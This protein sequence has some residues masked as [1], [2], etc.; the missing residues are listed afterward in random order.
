MSL[1]ARYTV[2]RKIA[3]GGT[4]E[5]FLAVQHGAKGFQKNVVLKRIHTAYYADPQFRNMLIDEAH[6]AMSLNHGN[7]VQV[8]D[9]GEAAGRYFLALELVDG[10]TAEQVLRRA[11]AVGV[12][13]PTELALYVAGEVCR[14]LAYAHA[15]ATD[16]RPLGIVHRDISTHNVLISEQGEVKLTDFGIAKINKREQSAG[17]VIKGKVAF[18]SPEQA[19]GETLDARSDI[20]SMGTMLYAM[21]TGRRPFDA[22]TDLETLFLVKSAKFAPPTP[23]LN[24][25]VSRIILKAMRKAP[26]ERYQKADE[27]LQ[28]IE[29]VMRIG[30]PPVG[31]TELKQWLGDLGR[32]DSA[33]PLTKAAAAAAPSAESGIVVEGGE[34]G[35][36]VASD[37]VM[38]PPAPPPPPP[39]G[40]SVSQGARP[41]GAAAAGRTRRGALAAGSAAVALAVVALAVTRGWV[42]AETPPQA[43]APLPL[44]IDAPTAAAEDAS[45]PAIEA[46][47]TPV[48]APAAGAAAGELE[49]TPDSPDGKPPAQDRIVSVPITSQPEGALVRTRTRT[50]GRTPLS[51]RFREGFSYELA[52]TKDGYQPLHHRI[53][54]SADAATKVTVRLKKEAPEPRRDPPRSAAPAKKKWYWPF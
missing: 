7:I 17:D 49:P 18:M 4:A 53:Q 35:A 41:A 27:M 16:G 43:P 25:Q 48:P 44:P 10:W 29:R 52:F 8:L 3:D 54:V 23:G 31:Q 38:L 5:I 34:A 9:L 51:Y 50:L 32:K 36:L 42:P 39:A 40:R 2:I 28:D 15:R 6:V 22:P 24:P 19:S 13:F 20:F 26:A 46:A 47:A 1:H 30:F 11:R 21:T 45:A 14:A 12:P 37:L 33:L